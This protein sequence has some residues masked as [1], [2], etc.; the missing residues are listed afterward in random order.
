MRELN[1]SKVDVL[2]QWWNRNSIYEDQSVPEP[3]E[4]TGLVGSQLLTLG[5][6]KQML[7]L[8]KNSKLS[9]KSSIQFL[10]DLFLHDTR[11]LNPGPY[12][13]QARVVPLSNFPSLYKTSLECSKPISGLY[14]IL[15]TSKLSACTYVLSPLLPSNSHLGLMTLLVPR[16]PCTE[17]LLNLNFQAV[18]FDL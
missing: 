12:A 8:W 11:D 6:E 18:A 10:E 15:N 5:A 2:I 7:V 3:L 17:N 1:S 14:L 13:P 16:S 4:Q 9:I